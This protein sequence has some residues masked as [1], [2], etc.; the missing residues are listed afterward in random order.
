ME[1]IELTEEDTIET[2]QVKIL[3]LIKKEMEYMKMIGN[4]LEY[5]KLERS[6]DRVDFIMR[7]GRDENI[8]Q[9]ERQRITDMIFFFTHRNDKTLE[10][11]LYEYKNLKE[12]NEKLKHECKKLKLKNSDESFGIMR[13]N[14]YVLSQY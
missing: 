14:G 9:D 10:E 2:C 12:E 3:K 7:D 8:I 11:I 4:M 5:E 1:T 6:F 13:K